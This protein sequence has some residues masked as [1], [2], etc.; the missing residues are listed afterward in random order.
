MVNQWKDSTVATPVAFEVQVPHYLRFDESDLNSYRI[1]LVFP[2]VF[3]HLGSSYN[4][5]AVLQDYT[6]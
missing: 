6:T 1:L 2:I 5:L 3:Q 4:K